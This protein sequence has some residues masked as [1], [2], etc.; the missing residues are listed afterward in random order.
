MIPAALPP[1]PAAVHRPAPPRSGELLSVTSY[2]D[3]TIG[4]CR[5][6]ADVPPGWLPVRC[7]TG[8][9]LG[10]VVYRPVNAPAP[11]RFVLQAGRLGVAANPTEAPPK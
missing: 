7:E 10:S 2:A 6:V 9:F 5:S 3:G 4:E 1:I 8:P 11:R